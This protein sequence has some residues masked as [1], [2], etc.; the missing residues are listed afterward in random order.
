MIHH[1]RGV[2]DLSALEAQLLFRRAMV[3]TT[4][5][6]TRV[7]AAAYSLAV[8]SLNREAGTLTKRMVAAINAAVI[9]TLIQTFRQ[10][11][12]VATRMPWFA[13]QSGA[14]SD[15]GR[16]PLQKIGRKSSLWREL[17]LQVESEFPVA[18]HVRPP[19]HDVD[20]ALSYVAVFFGIVAVA[21]I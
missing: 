2:G 1:D 6:T 4:A 3:V 19:E 13:G 8:E 5:R 14:D 7:I 12:S 17:L 9:A 15:Q 16:P 10:R 18:I 21:E 11:V 20:S